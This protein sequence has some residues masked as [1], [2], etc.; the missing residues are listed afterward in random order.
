MSRVEK[1]KNKMLQANAKYL[2]ALEEERKTLILQTLSELSSSAIEKP[3]VSTTTISYKVK[4]P[5][6]IIEQYLDGLLIEGKVE[7]VYVKW[8]TSETSKRRNI[9]PY[10]RPK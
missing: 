2:R 6:K 1:L 3:F 8:G 10:Y 4:L 9:L 7:R 5:G